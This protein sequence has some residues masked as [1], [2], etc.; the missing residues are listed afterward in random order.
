MA[1]VKGNAAFVWSSTSDGE[2]VLALRA[3]LRAVRAGVRQTLFVHE[4]LNYSVRETTVTGDGVY[5]VTADLRYEDAPATLAAFLLAGMRGTTLTYVPDMTAQERSI[6]V[7]LIEPGAG[8]PGL[9]EA[10]AVAAVAMPDM[11]PDS[12]FPGHEWNSISI[13]IRKTDGSQFE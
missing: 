9:S 10:S 7:Y 5:E 4:D 3:P 8:S 6:D 1:T 13:T 11:D 12:G 2:Q